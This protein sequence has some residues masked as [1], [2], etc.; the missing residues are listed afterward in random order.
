MENT[1]SNYKLLKRIKDEKFSVDKLESYTLLLQIGIQDIQVAVMD[2]ADNRCIALEDIIMS[3]I[4]SAEKW[5]EVIEDTFEAGHTSETNMLC[6][7]N[8]YNHLEMI[9]SLDS[10][11]R[12]S[13]FH[14][15]ISEQSPLFDAW[16]PM[17]TGHGWIYFLN[18]PL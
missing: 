11:N 18:Q 14:Q 2:T 5:Q 1:Q 16:T 13:C 3:N 8:A 15:R 12:K 10:I 6:S 9:Q 4:D 17:K 7:Q